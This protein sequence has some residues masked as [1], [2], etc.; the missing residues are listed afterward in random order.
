MCWD[1]NSLWTAKNSALSNFSEI[2]SAF[3]KMGWCQI[4]IRMFWTIHPYFCESWFW[5]RHYYYSWNFYPQTEY[6]EQKAQLK[7][8]EQM[9]KETYITKHKARVAWLSVEYKAL[10]DSLIG[11]GFR[12][13][14]RDDYPKINA[15]TRQAF[16]GN[17]CCSTSMFWRRNTVCFI[18]C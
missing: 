6:Q 15:L 3:S 18:N 14:E 16:L 2:L 1:K 11:G 13:R 4:F 12:N 17:S 9:Q 7:H 8:L 5:K 10:Q